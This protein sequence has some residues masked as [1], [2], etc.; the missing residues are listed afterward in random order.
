MSA[1]LRVSIFMRR[2]PEIPPSTIMRTDLL[3]QGSLAPILGGEK[4]RLEM[5]RDPESR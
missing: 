2:P 1:E 5:I 3:C 4:M